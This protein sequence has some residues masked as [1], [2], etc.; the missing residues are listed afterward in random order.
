MANNRRECPT[1]QG[2]TKCQHCGGH[3]KP[4]DIMGALLTGGIAAR[5][6]TC[7][8]CKGSGQCPRCRGKGHIPT[9]RK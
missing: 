7:G 9:D 5:N 4:F 6:T 2:N 8:I 1:C 3:G